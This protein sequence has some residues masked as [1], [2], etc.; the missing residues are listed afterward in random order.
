MLLAS[1]QIAQA[2]F[3]EHLFEHNAIHAPHCLQ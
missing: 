1:P 3:G 2:T